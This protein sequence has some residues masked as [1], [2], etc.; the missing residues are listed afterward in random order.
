MLVGALAYTRAYIVRGKSNTHSHTTNAHKHIRAVSETHLEATTAA[1]ASAIRRR[2]GRSAGTGPL[3]GGAGAG[4][5]GRFEFSEPVRVK[6]FAVL[7]SLRWCVAVQ[8]VDR[9]G[10][11][12]G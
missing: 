5:I 1:A 2:L 4:R 8:R 11:Y 9:E 7:R 3:R 10:R 12:I 6:L